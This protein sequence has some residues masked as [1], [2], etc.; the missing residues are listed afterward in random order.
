MFVTRHFCKVY[1]DSWPFSCLFLTD[2]QRELNSCL[3]Q[4]TWTPVSVQYGEEK[5]GQVINAVCVHGNLK[6]M[7]S[8]D[9]SNSDTKPVNFPGL[10]F[11]H[12][13][14][15]C[16]CQSPSNSA[17]ADVFEL[18][19]FKM[20]AKE[21]KKAALAEPPDV[22]LQAPFG[23]RQESA[24]AVP[25]D[26]HLSKLNTQPPCQIQPNKQCL[27]GPV[28]PPATSQSFSNRTLPKYLECAETHLLQQ[29]VA[30]HRVVSRIGQQA[31]V[32]SV[33]VGPLHSWSIGGRAL[34]DPF[35]A[36]PFHP[37]CSQGKP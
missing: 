33:A 2:L 6:H 25:A 13:R 7:L 3:L 21:S 18:A 31:A 10:H 14:Q 37:R 20:A 19:P 17:T 23:K 29:P 34:E 27:R 9:E 32:G 8:P 24:K 5:Q 22:F 16:Q 35:T 12:A 30:V 1:F 4:A 15:V 28:A 36:A 11:M 26:T